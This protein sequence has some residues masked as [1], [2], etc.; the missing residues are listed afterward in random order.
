[1]DILLQFLSVRKQ[2]QVFVKVTGLNCYTIYQAINHKRMDDQAVAFTD[3]LNE[4]YSSSFLFTG[5]ID[6]QYCNRKALEELPYSDFRRIT[7]GLG[8]ASSPD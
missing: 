1:M 3:Y 8:V 5:M 2:I 7:S 4:K 6:A